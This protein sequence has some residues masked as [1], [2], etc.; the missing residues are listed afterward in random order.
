MTLLVVQI[1]ASSPSAPRIYLGVEVSTLWLLYLDL[2]Q[3]SVTRWTRVR[4][5]VSRCTGSRKA[6]LGPF[7]NNDRECHELYKKRSTT[8]SKLDLNPMTSSG[9]ES[10]VMGKAKLSSCLANASAPTH[11]HPQTPDRARHHQRRTPSFPKRTLQARFARLCACAWNLLYDLHRS[12]LSFSSQHKFFAH[13]YTSFK[14]TA[15]KLQ[16]LGLN[17]PRDDTHETEER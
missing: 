17:H 5:R 6:P 3:G 2:L 8:S 14:K 12:S 4:P 10:K 15:T 16:S 7:E 13:K 11:F 1:Q 9:T